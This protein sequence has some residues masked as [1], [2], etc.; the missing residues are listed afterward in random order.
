MCLQGT[1]A[2]NNCICVMNI[3]NTNLFILACYSRAL[4][5]GIYYRAHRVLAH[6]HTSLT[7][8]QDLNDYPLFFGIQPVPHS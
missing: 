5:K 3:H 4:E 6:Q 8:R 7:A 2:S 1:I